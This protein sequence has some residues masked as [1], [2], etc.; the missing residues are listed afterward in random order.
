MNYSLLSCT[1]VRHGLLQLYLFSNV[2]R[3]I[4]WSR[5][6][7]KMVIVIHSLVADHR[8]ASLPVVTCAAP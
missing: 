1:S 6:N 3:K 7:C 5:L 4:Q 2:Y 8:F